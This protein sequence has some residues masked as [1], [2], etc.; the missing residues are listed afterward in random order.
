MTEDRLLKEK[1]STLRHHAR[2]LRREQTDA[3]RKLR[4]SLRARQING[5]KFRRQHP[6]GPYIVDF[7]CIEQKLAVELDGQK[8]AE[9]K[10]SP[11][12]SPCQGRGKKGTN[13]VACS[14]LAPL[15]RG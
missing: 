5:A 3:E 1:P 4:T 15:G 9:E 10:P 7:C 6:I 12:S 8:Q 14:S 13:Q 2:R 11:L